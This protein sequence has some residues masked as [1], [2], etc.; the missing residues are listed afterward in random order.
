[1]NK[2]YRNWLSLVDFIPESIH[3]IN[4]PICDKKKLDFQYVGDLEERIGLLRIWCNSC[5]R[6][7][8]VC[9]VKIPENVK[10]IP[11]TSDSD[12]KR[13]PNFRLIHP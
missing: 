7:I 8:H 6:G 5:L 9:R 2:N 3:T 4:C 1:M 12:L 10:I 13:V 11:F